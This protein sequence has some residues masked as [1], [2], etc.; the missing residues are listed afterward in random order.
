M[1][2]DEA[3]RELLELA[4]RNA[5]NDVDAMTSAEITGAAY[6]ASRMA[7]LVEGLDQ[8]LSRASCLPERWSR[9]R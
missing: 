3:L 7:D 6:D 4:A 5:N 9:G 2:P 1:D 8:W